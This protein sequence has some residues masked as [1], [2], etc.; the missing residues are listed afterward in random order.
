MSVLGNYAIRRAW[1]Q[2]G[3]QDDTESAAPP[4]PG[5][6]LSGSVCEGSINGQEWTGSCYRS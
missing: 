5:S 1:R 3:A 2:R 6:S 4:F